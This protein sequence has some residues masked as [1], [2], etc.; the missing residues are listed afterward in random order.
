M[1]RMAR[2]RRLHRRITVAEPCFRIEMI[3]AF[4]C[5][6]GLQDE[7]AGLQP[8]FRTI[9]GLGAVVHHVLLRVTR[10]M[11]EST[12]I[13]ETCAA[14]IALAG[15]PKKA[16]RTRGAPTDAKVS[17]IPSSYGCACTLQP[18]VYRTRLKRK[19]LCQEFLRQ[20]HSPNHPMVFESEAVK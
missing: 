5:C 17:T 4:P 12:V 19:L 11:H 15:G 3:A 14:G 9:A 8:G 20:I 13:V 6:L 1:V 16:P 7:V 10:R 2:F 18:S